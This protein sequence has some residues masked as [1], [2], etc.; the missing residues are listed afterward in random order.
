MKLERPGG[1]IPAFFVFVAKL[2]Y[3]PG[4][5]P[6]TVVA[7]IVG[8]P[9]VPVVLKRKPPVVTFWAT[10]TPLRLSGVRFSKMVPPLWAAPVIST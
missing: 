1:K 4:T 8:E 2:F 9:T 7:T 10:V 6:R 5:S 3:V